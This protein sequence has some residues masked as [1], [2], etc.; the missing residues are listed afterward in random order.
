[1]KS[2]VTSVLLF[3]AVA[4]TGAMAQYTSRIDLV[5]GDLNGQGLGPGNSGN[6]QVTVQPGVALTGDVTIMVHNTFP[7]SAITPVAA[8]PTWGD[9]AASCWQIDS[10]APVGD[11]NYD[12]LINLTAPAQTGTYYILFA[13]NG[14]YNIAQIMS[15]THPAW[16][17]DWQ[18]GNVV[19]K[20]PPSEFESAMGTGSIV[21][22]DWFTPP[23]GY[24]EGGLSL[25]AVRV[26]VTP[27]PTTMALLAFSGLCACGRR[28]A[29]A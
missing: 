5:S 29:C 16:P 10:W 13:M 1:M 27:E 11:T 2:S 6:H 25:N 17:A 24:A 28:R 20:R 8:S 22:F 19:V 9:P 26:V 14:A 12:V 21:P 15:G 7:S 3:L 18:N 4:S 23:G